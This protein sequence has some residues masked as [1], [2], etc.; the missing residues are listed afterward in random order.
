MEQ[1]VLV[2]N[3][4]APIGVHNKETVHGTSTP[5]HLA[6]SCHIVDQNGRLLITRRALTKKTWPGVWTNSFCGHPGPNERLEDAVRRRARFELGLSV[7]EIVCALPNFGYSARD[8]SGIEENEYCPVFIAKATSTL[9]P[10][11][12]EVAEAQWTSIAALATA[13]E[14]APWAFSPWLIGHFPDLLP[15]L[16][17][18]TGR[19]DDDV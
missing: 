8:P 5:R 4:G 9:T 18:S 15:I 13:T 19:R 1:V 11:P 7:E 3:S 10:N 17:D 6:F 16:S 14:A 12:D 2:D